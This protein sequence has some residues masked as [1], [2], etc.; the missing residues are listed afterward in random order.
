MGVDSFQTL[1]V[2]KFKF[3]WERTGAAEETNNNI[4]ET[5]EP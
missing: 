5:Q 3:F 2:K 1:E 4:H